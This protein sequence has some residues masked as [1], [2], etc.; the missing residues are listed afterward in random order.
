MDEETFKVGAEAVGKVADLLNPTDEVK[1]IGLIP[2]VKRIAKTFEYK[3]NLKNADLDNQNI[4]L[5][6]YQKRLQERVEQF[7]EQNPNATFNEAN[8]FLLRKQIDDSQ[9]SINNDYMRERFSRLIANTAIDT[10]DDITPFF[11]DV[12]SQLNTKTAQFLIALNYMAQNPA[13]YFGNNRVIIAGYFDPIPGIPN[14]AIKK[15]SFSGEIVNQLVALGL[16]EI[17]I[18]LKINFPDHP[19]QDLYSEVMKVALENGFTE[20]D[21]ASYAA[22]RITDFGRKFIS[23]VY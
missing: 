4:I 9:Y 16:V 17:E 22:V 20:S 12:L 1:R 21:L 13:A 23:L 6:A 5:L 7:L 19:E 2:T 14:K 15:A 10:S 3:R 8:E 11:S 18:D